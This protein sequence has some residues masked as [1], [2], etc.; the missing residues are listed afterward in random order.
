M[1]SMVCVYL[2]IT[3]SPKDER[4]DAENAFNTYFNELSLTQTLSFAQ[5]HLPWKALFVSIPI[6]SGGFNSVIHNKA[7]KRRQRI[8][9]PSKVYE[10]CNLRT[11]HFP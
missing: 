3:I 9:L 7:A 5:I 4:F 1:H 8:C 2:E 11:F 6:I 10:N